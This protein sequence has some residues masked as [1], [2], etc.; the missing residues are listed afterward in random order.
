MSVRG[1]SR[2]G[3]SCRRTSDRGTGRS[4]RAAADPHQP[5]RQ[6][7]EVRPGRSAHHGGRRAVRRCARVWVDDE[8]AGIPACR[9]G[10]VCST[11]STAAAHHVESRLTGSGIGLAVVMQLA[12]LHGGRAWADDA[13]GRGARIVVEFPGAYLRPSTGRPRRRVLA[14]PFRRCSR[15]LIVEDN[16]DLAFGLRNNLEIEGYEIDMAEDGLAGLERARR[17]S[18]TWSYSIS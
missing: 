13:P 10:T 4:W 6:R 2:S 5:G 12:R 7:A 16:P 3:P 15:I 14:P 18:P 9:S 17:G 8:G 1:R 11:P